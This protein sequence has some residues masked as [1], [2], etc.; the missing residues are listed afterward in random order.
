MTYYYAVFHRPLGSMSE[1]AERQTFPFTFDRYGELL[2]AI[3]AA[4]Y[5]FR[6]FHDPPAAGGILLRHDVDLSVVSALR[7]AQAEANRDI[8]ST[9]H[10][11]LSSPLYNPFEA[12]TRDRIREIEA[13]GHNVAL[14]FSTHAYWDEEPSQSA[15]AERIYGELRALESVVADDLPPTVSFHI[16][17][18][19]ILDRALPNVRSTYAPRYFSDIG[20]VADSGQRWREEPPDVDAL[21]DRVQMLVHPGLWGASDEGFEDRVERAIETAASRARDGAQAEFIQGVY[22]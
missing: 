14:H 17:P 13:L 22:S 3:R 18:D 16:P 2:D 7:M 8:V 11:L 6:S 1:P 5:E 9:Y 10:V 20:Y 12:V 15:L 21:P 4:D 19:W